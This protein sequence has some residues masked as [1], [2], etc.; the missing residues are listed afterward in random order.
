M[1]ILNMYMK[2]MNL[3]TMNST[4]I[5]RLTVQKHRRKYN[6]FKDTRLIRKTLGLSYI[7]CIYLAYRLMKGYSLIIQ[8][9]QAGLEPMNNAW[10]ISKI[11]Q[12]YDNF[13]PTYLLYMHIVNGV[14]A[15]IPVNTFDL[16]C[17]KHGFS[18]YTA[19]KK[20]FLDFILNIW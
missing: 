14:E 8:T 12:V 16:Y 5:V 9:Y 2:N 3:T 7:Q 13:T 17:V 19:N 4:D 20:G 15:Q 1:N 11:Q 10:L 18:I 6:I